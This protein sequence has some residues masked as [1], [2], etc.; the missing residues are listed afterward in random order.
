MTATIIHRFPRSIA[1]PAVSAGILGGAA[2]GMAG[3]G[4]RE[5]LPFTRPD[6]AHR[7][8]RPAPNKAQPPTTAIPGKRWHRN[9]IVLIPAG[10]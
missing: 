7:H 3:H 5:H 10:E 4:Q 9:H 6:T 1:L 2:L 8:R